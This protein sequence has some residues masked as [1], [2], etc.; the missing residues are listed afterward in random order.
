MSAA[1]AQKLATARAQ[2]TNEAWSALIGEALD[3]HD[4][5][6]FNAAV[7]GAWAFTRS[8]PQAVAMLAFLHVNSKEDYARMARA[9]YKRK[10]QAEAK[11]Q[12]DAKAIA[13]HTIRLRQRVEIGGIRVTPRSATLQRVSYT[14]IGGLVERQE[15]TDPL[16][17]LNLTIENITEGQL[18]APIVP[19]VT[20][21]SRYSDDFNNLHRFFYNDYMYTWKVPAFAMNRK[22][23]PGERLDA[24]LPFEAPQIDQATRFSLDLYLAKSND[25]KENDVSSFRTDRTKA[26]VIQFDRSEIRSLP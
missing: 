2:N 4:E 17:C 9:E 18:F 23:K 15:Q 22:I 6:L 3:S 24:C 20:K 14:D 5:R 1:A 10:Q 7:E 16:L 8:S 25:P 21:H 12:Q 26:I 13:S 11:K 19:R